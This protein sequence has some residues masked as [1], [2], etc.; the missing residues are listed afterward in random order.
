[1]ASDGVPTPPKGLK[2][3]GRRLW[4]SALTNYDLEVHEEAILLQACRCVDRLDLL[5]TEAENNPVTVINTKGDQVAHPAL[6][7]S[8]QQSIVLARLIASLRMPSGE[9]S[10]ELTRPQRRGASRGV[11]GIRGAV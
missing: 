5:A 1:M 7:E 9:Q 6:T 10:G 2:T 4:R 11:Y 8:R 3:S